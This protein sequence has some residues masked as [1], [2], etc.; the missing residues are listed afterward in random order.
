MAP[1]SGGDNI[2]GSLPSGGFV[3]EEAATDRSADADVT[4]CM[5]LD[6]RD[7]P[8]QCR[9][10]SS[11]DD[12]SSVPTANFSDDTDLSSDTGFS[13]DTGF[14][15]DAGVGSMSHMWKL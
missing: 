11:A 13:R 10:S 4:L 8:G 1:G 9:L 7:S 12:V 14:V 6:P 3:E 5:K 2:L 15:G